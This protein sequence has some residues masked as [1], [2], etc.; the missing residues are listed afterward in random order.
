LDVDCIVEPASTGQFH[1]LEELLRQRGFANDKGE[2]APIRRWICQGIRV[3][4]MPTRSEI[5]GFTNEWYEEGY[6]HTRRIQL[7][8]DVVINVPDAP[9]FLAIKVAA[10]HN[11]GIGD[12]RTSS[13]F[14][15]IV[16]LLRNRESIVSEIQAVDSSVKE[17]LA[18]SF[19][20]LL[21]ADQID[22]ALASVLD[23]GEPIGT[24][25]R[26]RSLI[27]QISSIMT[28]G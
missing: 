16:Y 15:D 13:D 11:R 6:R 20:T 14:E 28:S 17:Y 2:G 24:Q 27:Q 19:T 12:L 25:R 26:V 4:V 9:Y 1:E 22:E 8:N 7:G 18:D 21:S 10:L 23:Y 5:L 3:D